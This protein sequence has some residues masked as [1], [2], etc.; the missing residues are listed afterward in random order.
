MRKNAKVSEINH[1][2]AQL[3]ILGFVL[4]LTRQ[5]IRSALVQGSHGGDEEKRKKKQIPLK[6]RKERSTANRRE[7]YSR[8]AR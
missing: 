3:F 8:L 7:H 6:S 4:A 5:E 1:R 2:K